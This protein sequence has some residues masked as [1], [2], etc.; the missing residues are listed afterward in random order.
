MDITPDLE[1][2]HRDLS[3]QAHSFLHY[4][5]GNPDLMAQEDFSGYKIFAQDYP[6][7]VQPWP[8]F[9]DKRKLKEVKDAT[10]GVTRLTKMIPEAIFGNDAKKMADYYGRDERMIALQL[11]EPTG[12]AHNIVRCDFV[13]SADKGFKC[14]EVNTD[15]C[16]GGWQIN[17]WP[18]AFL[19][20]PTTAGFLKQEGFKP[21]W[22]DPVR[23]LLLH[24]AE[25]TVKQGVATDTVNLVIAVDV[26][27]KVS[28]GMATSYFNKKFDRLKPKL[29]IEGSIIVC[30]YNELI[31]KDN[32]L[33]VG[34]TRCHTLMHYITLG[35]KDPDFLFHLFKSGTLTLFNAPV[36]QL[37][38][39]KRNLALLS[40]NAHL[41]VF[42]DEDRRII[43]HHVPWSRE[44]K[45][46]PTTYRGQEVMLPEFLMANRADF[47]VKAGLGHSGEDV[48]V[49]PH[50]SQEEWDAAIVKVA[51][52][53]T[54]LAQEYLQSRSH[55]YLDEHG[56]A[57]HHSVWGLY[58]FGTRFAGGFIRVMPEDKGNGVINSACGATESIIF[59]V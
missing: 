16:L 42:S 39:D 29:G 49:G 54:W 32:A 2:N 5:V 20:S 13:D 45:P 35:G 23:E 59:V 7:A 52:S 8:T 34:N 37:L 46:G 26:P 18:G 6:F 44:L 57:R 43:D 3:E 36:S 21:N 30:G 40:Q 24:M 14:V 55:L 9:I 31:Q 56:P 48:L 10:L 33:Y 58:D 4:A 51:P 38:G 28:F 53:G 12:I 17:M 1:A 50:T 15:S 25:E 19:K 27:E 41:P 47:V 11:M 22:R